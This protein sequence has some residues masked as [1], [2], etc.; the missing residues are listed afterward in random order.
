MEIHKSG[1]TDEVDS[2]IAAWGTAR[3]DLDLGPL[4]VFS[5]LSRIAKHLDRARAH[6]FERSGLAYWEFD[7]L[8]VLRRSESPYR[9][10]PK[11]LVRQTMVSSGT[12]TN[13]IDRLVERGL[14]RRLTDPNDGRGVL[15]EM[16]EQGQTLVDAA[17]TRLTDAEERM[18]GAVT[19]AER[20][21]LATLLRKLSLS[22]DRFEP[23]SE[24]PATESEQ[25]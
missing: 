15:V 8:A 14:V 25:P 11:F 21:R 18:L 16:T 1:S 4:A 2:I 9:Q 20:E 12:M 22:V 17:M 10:S 23:V 5:R 3:P 13:R 6:A 24:I 19:R 7:V